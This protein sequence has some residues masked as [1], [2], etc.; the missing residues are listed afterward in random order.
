MCA[1]TCKHLFGGEGLE[2]LD[3]KDPASYPTKAG[4]VSVPEARGRSGKSCMVKT[5]L[6]EAQSRRKRGSPQET[7]LAPVFDMVGNATI[8]LQSF[9]RSLPGSERETT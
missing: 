2:F 7:V 9:C 8:F 3:N 1:E 4:E 6:S 5:A